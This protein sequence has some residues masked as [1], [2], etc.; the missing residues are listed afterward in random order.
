MTH[1]LDYNNEEVLKILNDNKYTDEEKKIL[2]EKY[3]QDLKEKRKKAIIEKLNECAKNIPIITK[4]IYI[5]F[6]KK[7]ENDNLSKPFEVIE[8]EIKIFENDMVNKYNEYLNSKEIVENEE[9]FEEIVPDMKSEIKDETIDEFDDTMFKDPEEFKPST[10][11]S[12]IID[13]SEVS[14]LNEEPELLAKP[15]SSKEEE[16]EVMPEELSEPLGEKGN[17]SAI[18]LSIIAI[19]I[20]AVVMYSIIRL[21]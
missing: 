12:A 13:D 8:Q 1:E 5:D 11:I 2:F 4:E 18:I 6:L 20:G 3:K 14:V 15:L 21:K 10:S 9:P 16:K 17:A 19:I 7:Y